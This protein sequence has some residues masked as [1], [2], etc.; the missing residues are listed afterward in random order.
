MKIR[1]SMNNLA[2]LGL[3]TEK[4]PPNPEQFLVAPTK[5]YIP[6][7]IEGKTYLTVDDYAFH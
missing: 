1:S 7:S 4:N 2:I 3:I 5:I 6:N